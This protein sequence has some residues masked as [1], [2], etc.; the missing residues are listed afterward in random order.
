MAAKKGGKKEYSGIQPEIS[1]VFLL[2]AWSHSTLCEGP[3]LPNLPFLAPSLPWQLP[4]VAYTV[5]RMGPASRAA[6]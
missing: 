2:I 4:P 3:P 1:F 6:S 5:V